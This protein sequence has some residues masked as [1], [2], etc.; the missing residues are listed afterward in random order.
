MALLIETILHLYA[1]PSQ[2]NRRRSKTRPGWNNGNI[3]KVNPTFKG[4]HSSSIQGKLHNAFPILQR[5]GR[6]TQR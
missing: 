4:R 3:R 1:V 6:I 5:K 2:N